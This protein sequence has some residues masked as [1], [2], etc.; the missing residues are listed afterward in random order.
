MPLVPDRQGKYIFMQEGFYLQG[1]LNN[2]NEQDTSFVDCKHEHTMKSGAPPNKVLHRLLSIEFHV[3]Q[4]K[5]ISKGYHSLGSLSYLNLI[6]DGMG[7][8][9]NKSPIHSF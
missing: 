9:N 2:I 5:L 7:P 6:R 3:S 4:A 1:I 8:F